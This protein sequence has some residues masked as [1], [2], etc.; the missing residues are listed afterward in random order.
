[1]GTVLTSSTLTLGAGAGAVVV[2]TEG[3][4]QACFVIG[5][6]AALLGVAIAATIPRTRPAPPAAPSGL[7]P[8]ED[9]ATS[10]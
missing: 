9:V 1:M 10:A 2:P 4:F 6:A 5:A 3:A 7:T 8:R